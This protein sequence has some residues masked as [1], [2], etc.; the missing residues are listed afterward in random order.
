MPTNVKNSMR[1]K[2]GKELYSTNSQRTY[3]IRLKT[4][5]IN[6]LLKTFKK[7]AIIILDIINNKLLDSKKFIPMPLIHVI[8]IRSEPVAKKNENIKIGPLKSP[9]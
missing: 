3:C 1:L 6:I 7:I 8:T 9:K 2:D 4:K 5:F